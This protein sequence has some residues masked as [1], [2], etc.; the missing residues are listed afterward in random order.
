MTNWKAEAP[1]EML[2]RILNGRWRGPQWGA[3][4]VARLRKLTLHLGY[5]WKWDKPMKQTAAVVM[6]GRKREI[7]SAERWKTIA[8]NMKG[9]EK[10]LDDYRKVSRARRPRRSNFLW[11]LEHS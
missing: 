1:K 10:K 6:K 5:E 4:K 3:M 7:H 9:M 8:D 11:I 2:P